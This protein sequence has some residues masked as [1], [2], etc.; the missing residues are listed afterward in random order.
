MPTPLGTSNR[1]QTVVFVILTLRKWSVPGYYAKNV[2]PL[3]QRSRRSISLLRARYSARF[4]L[5]SHLVPQTS[6]PPSTTKST[7]ML[8]LLMSL[9]PLSCHF[10]SHVVKYGSSFEG[11]M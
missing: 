9:P 5:M 3:F 11:G 6:S 10:R 7:G 2:C 8:G 4:C 1:G